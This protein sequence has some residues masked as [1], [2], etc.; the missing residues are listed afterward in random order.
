M[1]SE[2]DA[3]ESEYNFKSEQYASGEISLEEYEL[4]AAKNEA[5]DTQRKAVDKLTEQIDR[6]ESLSQ[7][8]IMPVLVNELGYNN[9]FYS[10]RKQK[11]PLIWR[12]AVVIL[13][14]SVFSIEK[15]SNM[16]ILNNC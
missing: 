11:Q 5:Y 12:W 1:R 10:Q 6:I 13:F 15:G 14:S 9:L 7:K 8:G 4:A 2:A 16:L 3:V